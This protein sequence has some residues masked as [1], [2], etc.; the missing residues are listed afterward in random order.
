[1]KI[2]GRLAEHSIVRLP[3]SFTA[4]GIDIPAGTEGVIVDIYPSR[5]AYEVEV[6]LVP[7]LTITVSLDDEGR[8]E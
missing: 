7:A 4:M 2:S 8:D 3:R 1:M 6:S 5:G